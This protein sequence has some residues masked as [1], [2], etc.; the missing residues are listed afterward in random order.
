MIAGIG[1]GSDGQRMPDNLTRTS[2]PLTG[3]FVN[4][5]LSALLLRREIYEQAAAD[6]NALSQAAAIVCLSAISQPSALIDAF[7]AWGMVVIML[8]GL[9]R[10][11]LFVA[12][13]YPIGRLIAWKPVPFRPLLRCLGFAE[14]PALLSLARFVLGNTLP[15]WYRLLLWLWLLAANVVAV[16][17]ALRISLPRAIGVGVCSFVLYLLA[18]PLIEALILS[19][20]SP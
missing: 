4:R 17:A 10:W 2:S 19:A 20:T 12:I 14:A 18:P 13:V 3:P 6:P 9:I 11:Y 15:D 8:I 5:I 7:G 16:R 1:E